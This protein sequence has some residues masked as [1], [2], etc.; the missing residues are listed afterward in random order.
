MTGKN[1][2]T[3]ENPNARLTLAE[4]P[5][6]VSNTNKAKKSGGSGRRVITA[7]CINSANPRQFSLRMYIS[8]RLP[9]AL[10]DSHTRAINN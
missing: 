1:I 10:A 3:N 2:N 9:A 7:I 6:I 4:A 8:L 5:S